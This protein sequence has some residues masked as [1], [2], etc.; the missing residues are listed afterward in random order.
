L[1][2]GIWGARREPSAR[3]H[4]LGLKHSRSHFKSCLCIEKEAGKSRGSWSRTEGFLAGCGVSPSLQHTPSPPL[5][6]RKWTFEM[7]SRT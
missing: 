5:A 2:W 1:G 3:H 6:G 4:S 7:T